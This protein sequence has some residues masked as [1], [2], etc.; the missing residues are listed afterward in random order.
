MHKTILHVHLVDIQCYIKDNTVLLY[1]YVGGTDS[2]KQR[3]GLLK[4]GA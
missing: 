2:G 3:E 1:L 4:Y